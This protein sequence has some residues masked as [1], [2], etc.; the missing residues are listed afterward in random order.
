MGCTAPVAEPFTIEVLSEIE[1]IQSKLEDLEIEELARMFALEEFEDGDVV[2]EAGADANKF[3]IIGL[4]PSL[5]PPGLEKAETILCSFLFLLAFNF[6]T[7]PCLTSSSASGEVE[8]LQDDLVLCTWNR[9]HF[10]GEEAITE[11]NATRLFTM[12]CVE[13]TQLLS[14]SRNAF[15][16]KSKETWMEPFQKHLKMVSNIMKSQVLKNVPFL[17]S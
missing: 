11:A 10:F 5:L 12:V 15:R 8:L 7:L 6:L 4:V 9:P 13:P 17:A 14:L 1:F 3:Y 2:Y 16:R